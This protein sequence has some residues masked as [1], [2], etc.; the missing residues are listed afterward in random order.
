MRAAGHFDRSMQRPSS[1]VLLFPERTETDVACEQRVMCRKCRD[2]QGSLI[3]NR[4]RTSD[5][6]C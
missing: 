5:I 1:C 6:H 4:L 3:H 2:E